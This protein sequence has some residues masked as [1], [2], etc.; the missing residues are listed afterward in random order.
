[1]RFVLKALMLAAISL[2]AVVFFVG[3]ADAH[4][5]SGSESQLHYIVKVGSGTRLVTSSSSSMTSEHK[6]GEAMWTD[7]QNL[8]STVYY[9]E[10]GYSIY[11]FCMSAPTNP[12]IRYTP[13]QGS[14]YDLTS[15][16]NPITYSGPTGSEGGCWSND[17]DLFW[18]Y[19]PITARGS[20]G[21]LISDG[22]LWANCYCPVLAPTTP[23]YEVS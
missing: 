22:W 23:T 6:S 20:A 7:Y 4:S 19:W 13:Q 12:T 2:I 10:C 14:S 16:W 17:Q 9:V 5:T 11:P 8:F 15:G 18:I 1:M 21:Y 3:T